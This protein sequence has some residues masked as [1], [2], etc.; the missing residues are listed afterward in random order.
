MERLVEK[1]N[2]E[3]NKSKITIDSLRS[4]NAEMKV[5]SWKN[6]K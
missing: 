5:I 3:L 4:E 1:L 6:S 2:H